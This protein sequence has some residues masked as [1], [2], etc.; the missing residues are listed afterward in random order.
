MVNFQLFKKI[1]FVLNIFVSKIRRSFTILKFPKL[2]FFK[3]LGVE[4]L[5]ISQKKYNFF[6]EVAIPLFYFIHISYI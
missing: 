4:P 1:K 2:F 3:V 5:R 6:F